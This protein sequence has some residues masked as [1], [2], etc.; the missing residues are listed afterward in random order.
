[1]KRA[2][3]GE[4]REKLGIDG[5]SCAEVENDRGRA[6]GV[7][8]AFF[9]MQKKWA[10]LGIS[11]LVLSSCENDEKRL[12]R[13]ANEALSATMIDPTSFLTRELRWGRDDAGKKAVCG[14]VN[15]KNRMGAYIGFKPFIATDFEERETAYVV[16]ASDDNQSD[17]KEMYKQYCEMP[18]EKSNRLAIE[19]FSALSGTYTQGDDCS[20]FSKMMMMSQYAVIIYPNPTSLEIRKIDQVDSKM[21]DV[22]GYETIGRSFDDGRSGEYKIMRVKILPES[23][24]NIKIDNMNF[25]YCGDLGK[26]MDIMLEHLKKN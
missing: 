2:L 11:L 10:L 14:E 21:F 8:P 18:S 22:S 6:I 19:N 7:F 9:S 17:Y 13:A 20:N 25:K 3:F 12:E 4:R 16:I 26:A 5:D 24:Y 15:G 1:M 23:P